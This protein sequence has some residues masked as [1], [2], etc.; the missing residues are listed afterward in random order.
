MGVVAEAGLEVV[1]E[2]VLVLSLSLDMVRKNQA[3]LELL[4]VTLAFR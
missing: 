1:G 2:V 3:I 4:D